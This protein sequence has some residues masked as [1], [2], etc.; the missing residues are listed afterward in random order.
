MSDLLFDSF[1]GLFGDPQNA[2]G[3]IDNPFVYTWPEQQENDDTSHKYLHN[4]INKDIELT[5]ANSET[6]LMAHHVWEAAIQL[7]NLIIQGTINVK[8]KYVIELGAG[9][10]L[11]SIVSAGHGLHVEL[12]DPNLISS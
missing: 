5:L 7:S 1:G 8:E 3:D 10:A 9:A 11:P 12:I 6:D 4:P 2:H